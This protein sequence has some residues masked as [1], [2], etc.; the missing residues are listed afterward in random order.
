MSTSKNSARKNVTEFLKFLEV[1]QP[2]SLR[3]AIDAGFKQLSHPTT[4]K[5]LIKAGVVEKFDGPNPNCGDAYA[6]IYISLYRLGSAQY[7]RRKPA[8][9]GNPRAPEVARVARAIAL[10][11]S[12]GYGISQ[13]GGKA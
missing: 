6:R 13:P 12:K 11:K 5:N 3:Q 9:S 1:N 10:L 4:S 7:H 2:I 8:K